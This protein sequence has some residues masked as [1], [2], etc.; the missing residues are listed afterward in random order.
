MSLLIF[1]QNGIYCAQADVY[2]DPWKPVK[3]ALITHAH[4]DHSRIGMEHYLAHHDSV[5][6]MKHRLGADI[7]ITGIGYGKFTV[8]NGV[9]FSFYPAGHIPGS[10]QIRVEYKGEIWVVSGDYK[11]EDDGL[12]EAFQPVP[13]HSFITES[14]FGLPIYKW[15]PQVEVFNEV[16]SWWQKNINENKVSV[17]AGYSLGKAQRILQNLDAS[18]GKIYTHGAVEATN[19]VLRTQGFSLPE[20]EL[21][22]INHKK[23]DFKNSIVVCPPSAINTPWMKKM[24]TVSTAFCSGWM[25][26]RGARRRRAMDRGFVLSDHADWQGLITAVAATQAE[27]VFVTHGYK[28]IFA[29]YLREEKGLNAAS[30]DTLYEDVETD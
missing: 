27:N 13:C 17:I 12:S 2:I 24:G 3:R 10:A 16:N 14:T 19:E 6:V 8:I 11:V 28:D 25:A 5:P 22:T 1:N 26:L 21:V 7:N 9:Q 15:Q 23:T 20:T 18:L 4:A 29:R 30:V